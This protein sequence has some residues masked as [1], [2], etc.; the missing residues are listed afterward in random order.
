[1][2]AKLHAGSNTSTP[3]SC[4]ISLKHLYN[5]YIADPTIMATGYPEPGHNLFWPS[6]TRN[7]CCRSS[8]RRSHC[9][10]RDVAGSRQLGVAMAF[11]YAVGMLMWGLFMVLITCSS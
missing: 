8:A 3:C 2:N 10:R 1:M 7:S 4:R 9:G 5:I 11:P 6:W